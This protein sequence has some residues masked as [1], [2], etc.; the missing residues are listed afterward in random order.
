MPANIDVHSEE[1]IAATLHVTPE[2]KPPI[3]R[4]NFANAGTD[5]FSRVILKMPTES[6]LV[7]P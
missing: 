3:L 1:H 4:Q 2:T 5:S 6:T 7:W